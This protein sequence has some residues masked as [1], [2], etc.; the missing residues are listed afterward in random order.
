MLSSCRRKYFLQH[1]KVSS[2][3][4]LIFHN[5]GP[6]VHFQE[7]NKEAPMED[8][9]PSIFDKFAD[10]SAPA[11]LR[12]VKISCSAR[13][14]PSAHTAAGKLHVCP[15]LFWF[16][17]TRE[18]IYRRISLCNVKAA[19]SLALPMLSSKISLCQQ[20]GAC[21]RVCHLSS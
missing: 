6:T 5:K 18:V 19:S 2:S 1:G 11:R 8:F 9:H 16:L 4:I 15:V 7:R 10:K 17:F 14:R 21:P 13:G 3:S 12:A 20:S